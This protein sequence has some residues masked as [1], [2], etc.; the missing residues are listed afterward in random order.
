LDAQAAAYNALVQRQFVFAQPQ[1]LRAPNQP[2]AGPSG[3]AKFPPS[4]KQLQPTA[5]LPTTSSG[6][7]TTLVPVKS[8]SRKPPL[9][10]ESTLLLVDSGSQPSQMSQKAAINQTFDN[11][12]PGHG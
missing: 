2:N 1:A 10:G 11:Y 6:G 12:I 5:G 7:G 8:K 3:T 9:P 4:P